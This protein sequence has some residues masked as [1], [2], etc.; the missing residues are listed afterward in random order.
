MNQE[1][2]ELK[3]RIRHG[4]ME[5]TKLF[6]KNRLL[7]NQKFNSEINIYHD[8]TGEEIRYSGRTTQPRQQQLNST[9]SEDKLTP[10]SVTDVIIKFFFLCQS[11]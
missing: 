9:P 10:D 7:K 6:E 1:N 8:L 4:A 5:Y 11:N 3:E 2:Q